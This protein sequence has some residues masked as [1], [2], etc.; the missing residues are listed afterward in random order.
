MHINDSL[1]SYYKSL[2]SKCKNLRDGNFIHSFWVTNG[3]IRIKIT[4]SSQSQEVSHICDLEELFPRNH[5]IA[6]MSSRKWIH[7]FFFCWV[8]YDTPW[9]ARY[10][11]LCLVF[12]F[13]SCCRIFFNILII[14]IWNYF[15]FDIFCF[16]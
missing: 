14:D 2:W 8:K 4:E 13:L 15:I 12:Y 11:I 9:W 3:S 10:D 16:S 5:C 6:D 1:C 7:C